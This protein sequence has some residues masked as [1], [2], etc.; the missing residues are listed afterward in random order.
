MP[1]KLCWHDF[2]CYY[3]TKKNKTMT[4]LKKITTY[5]TALCLAV[6]LF[7]SCSGTDNK[8]SKD[9]AEDMNEEKFDRKEEKAADYLVEAYSGNMYEIQVSENAA[10]NASDAEVKKIAAMMIQ[11]HTKMNFDVQT[12]ANSKGITLPTTLTED[13]TKCI[14]KI[15]DK[16]G[17]DYDREY[18]SDLKDKH[19][20]T[21]K[22]LEKVS[23]KCDDAEI[24][25]WAT[26]SIP[27]VQHHLNMVNATHET[28]KNRKS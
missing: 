27:E 6:T 15:T 14:Q 8:D 2:I 7:A 25:N 20:K 9:L 12:L 10:L 19:E 24:K 16:T 17:L 21:L 1:V 18:I 26:S 28:L 5:S 11:A 3:K 4:T 22:M 23:E 13:Q